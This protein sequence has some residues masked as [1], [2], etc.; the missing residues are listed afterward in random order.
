MRHISELSK[1]L[2]TQIAMDKRKL[3]CLASVILAMIQIRTVNLTELALCIASKAK[4]KSTYRRLQRLLSTFTVQPESIG[5][6]LLSWFYEE[7]EQIDL[8]M[9]RTHW[10][11][12]KIHLNFLVIAVPYKRMAIPIIWV[13]LPKAGNSKTSERIAL[14]ERLFRYLPKTRVR[15]LLCDREF[16]GKRWFKWLIK[17][18][19]RFYIRVKHNYLTST[20]TGKETTVSA[21]FYALPRGEIQALHGKRSLLGCRLYLTGARL[22]S[23][24]LMVI[25]SQFN[26]G[27][28][29]T[30]YLERWEI[31]TFFENAKSRG[32]NL[33]STH[34]TDCK[35]L[36]RLMTI[37]AISACWAYRAGTL[38]I[39][40]GELI[41]LKKHGRPAVS[42]L[43]EELRTN[44]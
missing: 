19:I 35:K 24:E 10:K 32:F 11:L 25:A 22:E 39:D 5:C 7:G 40:Q 3:D 38:K 18:N 9:D 43:H 23:G 20:Q 12:G 34:V 13:L 30:A 15:G 4:P 2:S 36:E 17:K 28:A 41:K 44:C 37:L 29:I 6:W 14:L 1:I 33:E 42:G 21:L 16:V 8:S 31:E 27:C 26:D